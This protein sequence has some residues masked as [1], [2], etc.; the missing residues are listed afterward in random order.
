MSNVLCECTNQAIEAEQL[1]KQQL[2]HLGA[3]STVLN[4]ESTMSVPYT[5]DMSW[6][7][8][9]SNLQ[10]QFHMHMYGHTTEILRASCSDQRPMASALI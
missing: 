6:Y 1:C 5:A 8:D 9:I 2:T 7:G 4:P 10:T 3:S